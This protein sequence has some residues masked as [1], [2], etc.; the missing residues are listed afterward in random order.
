MGYSFAMRV[1]IL[2]LF[3]EMF[4]G[5]LDASI[6]RI[7]REK[8]LLDSRLVNFRDFSKDKHGKVDDRPYGGGP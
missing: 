2:T 5:V 1:D 7:A 4:G 8:G 3:P 6:L